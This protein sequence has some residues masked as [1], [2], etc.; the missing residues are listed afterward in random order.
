M[1]LLYRLSPLGATRLIQRR[2]AH[3]LAPR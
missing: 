3:L 1:D 2:M